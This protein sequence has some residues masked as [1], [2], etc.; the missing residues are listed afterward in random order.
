MPFC[1]FLVLSTT[2]IEA[3]NKNGRTIRESVKGNQAWF[4]TI[5]VIQVSHYFHLSSIVI[6]VLCHIAEAW[7]ALKL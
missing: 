6:C 5:F 4:R 1:H 2:R 7:K 3:L